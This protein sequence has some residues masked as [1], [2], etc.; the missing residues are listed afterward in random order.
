MMTAT[1]STLVYILPV[2]ISR[3]EEIYTFA[4]HWVNRVL[5]PIS[6]TTIINDIVMNSLVHKN[7]RM[8]KMSDYILNSNYQI[9]V[10]W[11]EVY[12][13]CPTGIFK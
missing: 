13:L 3:C 7:V 5:L 11:A 8:F 6:I 12:E 9:C 10:Y 1:V 2:L 4:D